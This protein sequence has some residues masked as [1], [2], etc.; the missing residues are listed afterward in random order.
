MGPYTLFEPIATQVLRD[1]FSAS[2]ELFVELDRPHSGASGDYYS[3]NS[4]LQFDDLLTKASPG[5]VC[6]VLRDKQLP[7]RGL[8]DD[9][10]TQRALEWLE[11]GDYYI[12]VEP[13]SYPQAIRFLG[14]GKTKFELEQELRELRGTDVWVGQDFKFPDLYWK[15]NSDLNALII[16]KPK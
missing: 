3:L 16:T 14:D 11:D 6:F 12:I 7:L 2:T 4:Y 9:T 15:E 13:S 8:V 5:A 10:F 1:W